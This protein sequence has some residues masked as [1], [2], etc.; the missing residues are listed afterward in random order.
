MHD[1]K[2]A[3]GWGRKRENEKRDVKFCQLYHKLNATATAARK[4]Q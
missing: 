4:Q 3:Q 1:G 2:R